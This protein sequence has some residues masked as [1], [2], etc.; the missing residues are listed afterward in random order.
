MGYVNGYVTWK[1]KFLDVFAQYEVES[2]CDAACG[3]GAYS[4]MLAKNG[5]AVSGFDISDE[6]VRLT[7]TMMEKFSCAYGAYKVCGITEIEYGDA[8][9]N[10]VVAHAVIDHVSLADARA[11]L[12]ELFRI[13]TPGGLLFITFDPLGEEDINKKHEVLEDGSRLYEDGLRFRHYTDEDIKT[14]IGDNKIIHSNTNSHGER[15]YI[16]QK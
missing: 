10:A 12:G 5:Y 6:S 16:L 13:L 2:V 8:S 15:E 9:F 3:F 11:A 4:V 7:Q 1:P 14:L